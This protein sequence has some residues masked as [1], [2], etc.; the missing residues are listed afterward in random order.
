[1]NNHTC[2][3]DGVANRKESYH[4]EITHKKA[5]LTMKIK[6]LVV[7]LIAIKEAEKIQLTICE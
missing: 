2:S 1:M 3:A 4:S 6:M 5:N 7:R